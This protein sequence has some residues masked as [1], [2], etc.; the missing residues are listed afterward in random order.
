M[1]LVWMAWSSVSW[2]LSLA[3]IFVVGQGQD[4]FGALSAS[5]GLC[6]DRFGP[7]AAVGTWFGLVH[8]V[9]FML[10]TSVVTF[11]LAFAQI[12][13]G[14]VVL[15]AVLLLTLIY[16]AIVDT[17]YIAAWQDMLRFWKH[18]PSPLLRF[19]PRERLS[20]L[21]HQHSAFSR[22]RRWWIRMN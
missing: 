12:L 20:A 10:A 9:L 8:I 3:S 6:R 21:S 7:V 11:P 22:K 5:V 18:P 2:L 13:P 1:L 15:I 14:P 19:L 16:F 4:T 17:L